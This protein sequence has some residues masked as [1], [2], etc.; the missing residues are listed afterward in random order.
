MIIYCA[1]NLIN[2][3]L[4]IGKTISN[5]VHRKWAHLND[6]KKG[7]N[8][9]FHCAIRKYGDKNFKFF[10]LENCLPEDDLNEKEKFYISQFNSISPSGYNLTPGGDGAFAGGKIS[11]KHKDKI[12]RKLKGK[13]AHNKG[14]KQSIDT[15]QKKS[16]SLKL[17]YAE[18]RKISFMKGK[19]HSEE[20]KE[21][22]KKNGTGLKRTEGTKVKISEGNK[23]KIRSEETIKKISVAK[24]GKPPWNKGL[25]KETDTRVLSYSISLKNSTSEKVFKKGRIP[26][27]LKR[28]KINI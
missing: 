27:N 10:I 17:A 9:A 6:A 1:E 22:I 4:Y 11:Q 3:K 21:K 23:G 19:H 25:T 18:G 12:S 14:I 24:K 16:S 28:N 2:G 8:T 15:C 26:W 7:S 20:T 13:P 5:I